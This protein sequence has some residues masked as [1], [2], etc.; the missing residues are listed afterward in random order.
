MNDFVL[1]TIPYSKR[2]IKMAANY[3]PRYRRNIFIGN[4]ACEEIIKKISKKNYQII[5]FACHGVI[6]GNVPLRSALILSRISEKEDGLLQVRELYELKI[7]ANLVILSACQTGRGSLEQGEGVLGLPRVFFFN[8]A[9][10][11]V[12]TL[13]KIE[14]KPTAI[15]MKRFYKFLAQGLSKAQALRMAKQEMRRTKYKHPY[16]WAGFILT[17]DGES[18]V[19]FH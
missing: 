9:R 6:D 17:G 14:D 4:E 1:D 10:S 2:E 19:D 13:W 15:F 18:T 7:A 8:G 16:Y 12:S 11:V 5:H 3:F